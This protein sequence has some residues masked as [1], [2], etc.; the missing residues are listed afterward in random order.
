MDEELE[1]PSK[2]RL[3]EVSTQRMLMHGFT[4][5]I[6][7]GPGAQDKARENT[8]NWTV[9]GFLQHAI[10]QLCTASKVAEY[11]LIRVKDLSMQP[12]LDN[13]EALLQFL[14]QEFFMRHFKS[15]PP[16]PY[17]ESTIKN[18]LMMAQGWRAG[19][20]YPQAD[21]QMEARFCEDY[22]RRH[23][24]HRRGQRQCKPRRHGA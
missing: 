15:H 9:D 8:A 18:V 10:L 1:R 2:Q 11:T 17:N 6:G 20:A 19:W 14:D 5:Q 7:G 16:E 4:C 3:Q 13:T 23:R 22:S 12:A 21:A 24:L